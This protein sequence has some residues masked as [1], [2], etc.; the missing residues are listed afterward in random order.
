MGR[1]IAIEELL[2][3]VENASV[4]DA[5]GL[6]CPEPVFRARMALRDLS[7]G[8]V[9]VI[10]ADDPLAELDLRVFCERTAHALEALDV[11]EGL[12]IGRIRKA[13]DRAGASG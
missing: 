7:E 4:V 11:R 5:R 6:M 1:R 13:A 3:G 9:L 12:V 10:V 2:E 8:E